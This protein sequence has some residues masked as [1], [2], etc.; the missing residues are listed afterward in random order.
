LQ[1]APTKAQSNRSSANIDISY[2]TY[3]ELYPG[4]IIDVPLI[5]S[6]KTY[7]QQ[8][9]H[10][11]KI[12]GGPG[13][14]SVRPQKHRRYYQQNKLLLALERLAEKGTSLSFREEDLKK[15]WNDGFRLL[16]VH[17]HLS[18]A[19]NQAYEELLNTT[20]IYDSRSKRLFIPLPTPKE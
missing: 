8:Q 14:D 13:Q 2:K 16:I 3:T 5:A 4:G 7:V 12:I 18:K 6:E 10:K 11:Q 15:L 20:G 19:K 17:T 9:Y 1:H